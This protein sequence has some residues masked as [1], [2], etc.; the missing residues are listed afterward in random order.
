M[1]FNGV[2]DFQLFW[3]KKFG[4]PKS[5]PTQYTVNDAE[6]MA[7][8]VNG[9][10]EDNVGSRVCVDAGR[11]AAA[12]FDSVEHKYGNLIVHGS[13]DSDLDD[14][15]RVRMVPG[16]MEVLL[17]PDPRLSHVALRP[18]YDVLEI[19]AGQWK[20]DKG[21]KC[22]L[23]YPHCSLLM[24]KEYKTNALSNLGIHYEQPEY[25]PDIPD[26]LE[27]EWKEAVVGRVEERIF[28]RLKKH[29][30]LSGMAA[31]GLEFY[32]TAPIEGFPKG[33]R[34]VVTNHM[35]VS[36]YLERT[37]GMKNKHL[38]QWTQEFFNK[39]LPLYSRVWCEP[40]KKA[41]NSKLSV[42]VEMPE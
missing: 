33:N 24:T 34:H 26:S 28:P 21:Q 31:Y 20:K 25:S 36:F 8:L 32:D 35:F 18:K 13:N 4:W 17:H 2:F 39:E 38:A 42:L 40:T 23:L 19:D 6:L 16:T 14:R 10:C 15:L 1:D 7:R 22:V 27:E 12:S 3:Y 9:L 5:K 37:S 41:R 30:H 11:V 29:Y